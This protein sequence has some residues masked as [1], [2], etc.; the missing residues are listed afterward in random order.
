MRLITSSVLAISLVALFTSCSSDSDSSETS[1]VESSAQESIFI[2]AAVEGIGYNCQ[3]SG[4]TG[5]TDKDGKFYYVLG[6]ECTFTVGSSILGS[7]KPT[8]KFFTPRTLTMSEP[9]LTNMLRYLQT[10]DT[11]LTDDKITLPLN[12]SDD[13]VTFGVDFNN[14]M[15][16]LVDSNGLQSIVSPSD[17][18]LHFEQSTIVHLENSTFLSKTFSLYF[19]SKGTHHYSFHDNG[20]AYLSNKEN[21]DPNVTSWSFQ[22]NVLSID[23]HELKF[24]IDGTGVDENLNNFT[25]SSYTTKTFSHALL[26]GKTVYL[27]ASDMNETIKMTFN[28]GTWTLDF[29]ND[30]TETINYTIEDG[31]IIFS[32]DG[33]EEIRMLGTTESSWI[34]DWYVHFDKTHGYQL[35]EFTKPG[36]N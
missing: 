27:Y 20:L 28:N 34:V 18:K 21:V 11:D 2:D 31:K 3:A 24:H 15:Q 14:S 9:N 30:P 22:N 36:L 7:A 35:W 5:V 8:D 26:N 32:A 6:D 10:L 23:G 4:K 29:E 13:V 17:A 1:L 25:Y 16:K 33:K 19:T 12:L